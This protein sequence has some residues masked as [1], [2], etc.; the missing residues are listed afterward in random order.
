MNFV[1]YSLFSERLLFSEAGT[2]NVKN[3]RNG[4]M[5]AVLQYLEEITLGIDN[6]V[7]KKNRTDSSSPV[8]GL[9]Y[10]ERKSSTESINDDARPHVHGQGQGQGHSRT[11]SRF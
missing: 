10:E 6:D 3:A 8:V 11:S 1:Q 2:E 5:P 9:R 7:M 4:S